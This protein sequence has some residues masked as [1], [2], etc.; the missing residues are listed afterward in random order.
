M[1]IST[2][3]HPAQLDILIGNWLR[4]RFAD[5]PLLRRADQCACSRS[6]FAL[7]YILRFIRFKRVICPSVCPLDHGRMIAFLPASRSFSTPSANDPTSLFEQQLAA[8]HKAFGLSSS[9]SWTKSPDGHAGNHKVRYVQL[10]R[11]RK[12]RFGLCRSSPAVVISRAMT[13]TDGVLASPL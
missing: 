9:G 12:D 3:S 1:L 5:V 2:G 13:L 11:R 4:C 6:S 10:D 8:T 7:P